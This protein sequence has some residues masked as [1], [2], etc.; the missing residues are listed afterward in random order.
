M[1]RFAPWIAVALCGCWYEGPTDTTQPPPPQLSFGCETP[2]NPQELSDMP[3]TFVAVWQADCGGAG[4]SLP[5]NVQ[6]FTLT[7]S[8]SGVPC[9]VTRTPGTQAGVANVT[10]V[11]H[12]DGKLVVNASI[13]N[14]NNGEAVVLSSS[15]IEVRTMTG[16]TFA[17][18]IDDAPCPVPIPSGGALFVTPQATTAEG[19]LDL[20]DAKTT[21]ASGQPGTCESWCRWDHVEAGTLVVDASYG[22]FSAEDTLTIQ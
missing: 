5:C 14:V 20:Y 16:L 17:C 15:P 4:Q 19:P 21:V 11:P 18:T 13:T 2:C 6:H 10:V 22:A 9:D 3:I 1:L 7:A 8:C 12:G